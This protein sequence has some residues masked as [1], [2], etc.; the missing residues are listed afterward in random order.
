MLQKEILLQGDDGSS[1]YIEFVASASR[2]NVNPFGGSEIPD[3]TY[4]EVNGIRK[5]EKINAMSFSQGDTVRI[6]Y[7]AKSYAS[8]SFGSGSVSNYG[9][10]K[11]VTRGR[12]PKVDSTSLRNCF[13]NCLSLT[14]V[15][16]DVFYNNP[17]VTDFSSCFTLCNYLSSVPEGLFA[18]NTL[19]TSF[20]NCFSSSGIESIPEKIFS[21]LSELK[22]L[23]NCFA[24]CKK[25]K[26]LPT[27]LFKYNKKIRT[28]YQVFDGCSGLTSIPADLFETAGSIT[29][30]SYCFRNCGLTSIPAGLFDKAVNAKKFDYCFADCS[31][32]KEI[33]KD[34][35]SKNTKANKFDSCFYWCNNLIPEV[36]IGSTASSVSVEYFAR[37]CKSKGTVYCRAGSAAYTAFSNSTNANVNVLT[38]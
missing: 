17:Q 8:F 24:A 19:A 1:Q 27:G 30:F 7:G 13:Y 9:Y 10:L 29:E 34:L 2:S 18:K 28:F 38:Y 5:P 16:E 12:I 14:S 36:Q 22:E 31:D 37:N 4:Y 23:V 15:P 6:F 20:S 11:T 21:K 33:P 3:G 25:L 35:F 32:L 26:T